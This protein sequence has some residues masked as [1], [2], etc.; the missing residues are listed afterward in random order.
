LA[1]T[2]V[3]GPVNGQPLDVLSAGAD[4]DAKP[5]LATVIAD[6]ELR[7]IDVGPLDHARY[8][9]AARLPAHLCAD[10]ARHRLQDRHQ[11]PRLNANTH[12]A[13]E[14]SRS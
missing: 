10:L 4:E 8:L 9:E 14:R 12:R 1:A 5:A 6:K 3:D 13:N 11:D 2:L 7:P